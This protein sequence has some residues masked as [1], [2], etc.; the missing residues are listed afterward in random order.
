MSPGQRSLLF[1]EVN[2]RIYDLLSSAEPDLKGEFL[3][4]CGREC[5]RRV[6]LLPAEFA[7]LRQAGETICSAECRSLRFGLRR[8]DSRPAGGVPALN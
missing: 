1:S 5:G 6:M 8:C 3:C 7:T 4:E 2:D